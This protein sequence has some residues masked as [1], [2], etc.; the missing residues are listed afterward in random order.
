MAYDRH[1]PP[2]VRSGQPQAHYIPLAWGAASRIYLTMAE[3]FTLLAVIRLA[4]QASDLEKCEFPN[5]H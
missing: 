4:G 2:A 5:P 3:I 1:G